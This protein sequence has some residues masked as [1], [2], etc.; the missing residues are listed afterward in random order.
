MVFVTVPLTGLQLSQVFLIVE[1]L[2]ASKAIRDSKKLIYFYLIISFEATV[3][4]PKCSKEE[5][6]L[7]PILADIL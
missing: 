7:V 2:S 1:I 3:L 6:G 5:S 4:N